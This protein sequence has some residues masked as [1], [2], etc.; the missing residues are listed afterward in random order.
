MMSEMTKDLIQK[1]LDQDFNNANK[2]FG[3]IMNIKLSDALEQEK[4]RLANSVYNGIEPE[5]EDEDDEME[6]DLEMEEEEEDSESDS[7]AEES[8]GDEDEFEYEEDDEDA[9]ES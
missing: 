3:E 2:A 7:D 1:A 4:I 5:D 8:L 9:D 6:L